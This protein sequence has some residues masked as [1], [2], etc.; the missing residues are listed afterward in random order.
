MIPATARNSPG[1]SRRP[2]ASSTRCSARLKRRSPGCYS[3]FRSTCRTRPTR[4]LPNLG[5]DA[6]Q[7]LRFSQ[8]L[9]RDHLVLELAEDE[10]GLGFAA[11]LAGAGRSEER[12][13]G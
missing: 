13:V 10:G 3:T 8:R 6:T 5:T 9:S 12:R 1:T 7:S 2:P 4:D 11:D